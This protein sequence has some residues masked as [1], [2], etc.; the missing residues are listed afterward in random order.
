MDRSGSSFPPEEPFEDPEGLGGDMEAI[1][2]DDFEAELE[3]LVSDEG[4]IRGWI[5]PDD[6]L[7]VHPSEMGRESRIQDLD[8]ARRR[9]RRSDRRG[10]FAAGVVGTAALTAA[11]AA[12]ALAASSSG[13]LATKSPLFMHP[14]YLTN[15]A[16][17]STLSSD[18][19]A[20]TAQICAASMPPRTCNMVER[21]QSSMLRIVVQKGQ[22]ATSGAAVVIPIA[23]ETG[24]TVAITAA[25]LVGSAANVEGFDASGR[26]HKLEVLGADARTGIAV[27]KVPWA[28][29]AASIGQ[30][31]LSVGEFLLLTCVGGSSERPMS[32]LGQVDDPATSASDLMDVIDVDVTPSATPGGVLLDSE[33]N[34]VGL[35]AAKNDGSGDVTG[36]FVPAWFAIGVARKIV[37]GSEAHGW[38]GV[39]GTNPSDGAQGALVVKAPAQ[40]PAAAAG[41]RPG[42]LVVGLLSDGVMAPILSMSDL[43]AHLYIEPPGAKIE[44][45]VL[46]GQEELTPSPV[47]AGSLAASP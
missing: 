14:T 16:T 26:S 33:G 41:L 37:A 20:T 29:P 42:D 11:V 24:E 5:P 31:P 18:V 32:M 44:L 27:V 8:G 47:L 19:K 35:L 28:M 6:R 9:A 7:W 17:N 40:E 23:G 2:G 38:L 21:V 4:A 30:D 12:V 10:L 3:D 13:P 45:Q 22:N 1:P 43:E 39:E 36:E 25:S 34:M 46:R 15:S